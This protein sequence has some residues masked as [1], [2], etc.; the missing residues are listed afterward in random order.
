MQMFL[1]TWI[2]LLVGGR[3]DNHLFSMSGERFP[4]FFFFFLWLV[5]SQFL[6]SK[7]DEKYVKLNNY[8]VF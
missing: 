5:T 7:S 6:E 1:G 2:V 4:D 8:Y 3:H